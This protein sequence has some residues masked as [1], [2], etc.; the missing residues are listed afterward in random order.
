MKLKSGRTYWQAANTAFGAQPHLERNVVCEIAV[1]GGGILGALLAYQLSA[2]GLSVV[3]L[4]KRPV[5]AGST[6][7]STALL[8]YEL[9]IHLADL[10]KQ[11]GMRKAARVYALSLRSIGTLRRLTKELGLGQSF[12]KKKSLYVGFR[13]QDVPTLKAEHKIR[14]RQGLRCKLLNRSELAARFGLDAHAA[15]L[16]QQAAEVDPYRLTQVLLERATKRGVRIFDRTEVL[17]IVEGRQGSVLE[18]KGHTIRARWVVMAT[19]YESQ[20]FIRKKVVKLKSSYVIVSQPIPNLRKHWL[21][22]HLLWETERPY[23]YVRTTRDNRLVVGGEDE[24]TVNDKKRDALIP[25]KSSR[26]RARFRSLF[27]TIPF[28]TA[29]AWAGTFGE[30]TDGMG[31]IGVPTGWKDTQFVLGFGGNGIT[32]GAA[33]AELITAQLL[34]RPS[35]DAK[36]FSFQR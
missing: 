27:P 26:L 7:A 32:F 8:L 22:D 24:E 21:Y 13:K 20:R 29:F 1:V 4:D 36:L 18:T 14:Q 3:L 31:Y 5:G 2:H 30:T 28:D 10:R 11:I 16:S 15:I 35:P 6:S 25:R 34:G 33:A 17:K 19:G 12:R 9:D 23:L